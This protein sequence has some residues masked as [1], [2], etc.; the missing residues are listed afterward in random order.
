MERDFVE[1][2]SRIVIRSDGTQVV[3]NAALVREHCLRMCVNGEY[4]LDFI[5]SKDLLKELVVG[6]LY[7]GGYIQNKDDIC[8][9][10]CDESSENVNVILKQTDVNLKLD[11]KLKKVP[12]VDW[13]TE[14]I[15]GLAEIF[16]EGLPIHSKTQGT[17]SCLLAKEDRIIFS[18]EDIGRHNIVDKAVGYAI[19]NDISMKE[20]ILY[21]S[22]R[23]PAD[24]MRKVIYSGI[25]VLVS[26]AVP[27][28]DAVELAER[29][30][31]TLIV[32]AYPDQIEICKGR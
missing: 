7:I 25:P 17:H 23:V 10:V 9:I 1:E 31:V 26:K 18:C 24:M 29:Y 16:S 12:S 30:G 27:T 21:I 15:F 8:D 28:A 19:L 32:K 14:W 4:I 3:K 2:S 20:L 13:K 11:R 22:G 5:C 6:S